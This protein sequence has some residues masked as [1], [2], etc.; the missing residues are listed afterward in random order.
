MA[1]EAAIPK[2]SPV[3]P[4]ERLPKP[5]D[6]ELAKLKGQWGDVLYLRIDK[7]AV[8]VRRF[9]EPEWDR[10]QTS[11][12]RGQSTIAAKDLLAACVVWG[13]EPLELI[14]AKRPAYGKKFFMGLVEW[15]GSGDQLEKKEM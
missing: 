3:A 4:P 9:N 5:T 11:V 6:E 1:N 10:F 15:A 7:A 14:L 2:I 8:L 12:D 13:S